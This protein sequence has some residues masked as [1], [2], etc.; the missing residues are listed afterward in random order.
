MRA[1]AQHAILTPPQVLERQPYL[2]AQGRRWAAITSFAG[3]G[4][5][6][7]SLVLGVVA[8][9]GLKRFMFSYLQNYVF[10]VSLGLGALFFV[11]L[12]HLTRASW[13]V[14]VR[15]LAEFIAGSLPFMALLALPI[16]VPM[17]LGNHA[18]YAWLDPALRLSDPLIAHKAGYLNLGFFIARLV[19]Y[20]AVWTWLSQTFLTGSTKQDTNGDPKISLKLWRLSAPGMTAYA[21]TATFF[22]FDLVMSLDPRWYSTIFG[23]YFFAGSLVGFF[24]ILVLASVSLQASGRLRQVITVE[25]Y[26]DLGKLL[27]AFVFFWGYIAFSQFMLYWY[28]NIPEETAWFLKRQQGEWVGFSVFLLLF[29]LLIPFA[30]LLSR[31]LKRRKRALA[32]MALWLLA[33]HWI[34]M[35]YLVLPE[36][37]PGGTHV[38]WHLLD[39]TCLLGVGCLF[40]SI[41]LYRASSRALVPLNDPLLADSLRFENV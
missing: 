38:P 12:Q 8:G 19:L 26:H 29:H 35:Y 27:F 36:Y 3:L 24:G 40:A 4:L 6:L 31:L 30:I 32:F 41:C 23:V 28:A 22:A 7:I 18:L 5:V 1:T 15:R 25:H 34:D 20:F 9:D 33:A 16:L 11:M 21:L 14:V 37:A 10:F 17:L 39:L 2:G 13:S